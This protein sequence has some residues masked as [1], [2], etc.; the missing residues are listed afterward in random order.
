LRGFG[1]RQGRGTAPSGNKFEG[2]HTTG[3]HFHL[4]Q[5]ALKNISKT[6]KICY[7]ILKKTKME[8]TQ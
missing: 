8:R 3:A 4:G 5:A 6:S 7:A 2:Q 1:A